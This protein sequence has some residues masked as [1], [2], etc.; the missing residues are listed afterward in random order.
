MRWFYRILRLFF[1][2]HRFGSAKKL[3]ARDLQTDT[4]RAYIYVLRCRYCGKMKSFTVKT[5]L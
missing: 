1:C 3:Q 2:P 4:V 5:P